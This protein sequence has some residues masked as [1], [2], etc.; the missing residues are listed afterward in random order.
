MPYPSRS[1]QPKVSVTARDSSGARA[2]PPVI[3]KRSWGAAPAF[4]GFPQQRE[5]HL[6]RAH[7]AGDP[8]SPDE[9]K[10]CG[11]IET[12]DQSKGARR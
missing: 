6:R 9:A 10:R 7:D 2:A 4:P 5:E 11:G 3:P 12:L 8:R 1:G